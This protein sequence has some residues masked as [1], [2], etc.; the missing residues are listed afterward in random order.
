MPCLPPLQ[1]LRGVAVVWVIA[2]HY[3]ALRAGTADPMLAFLAQM[4]SLH[5][6]VQR[7]YLGV[8]LFFILSGF[9]LAL[10]W[11]LA[12]AEGRR[13]P[14]TS[15]FYRRRARRIVP[16]YYVQLLVLFAIVLPL[17]LGPRYWA[18]DLYVYLANGVAHGLFLHTTSP[19]T[20]ASM[21]V[22]GALWTLAVEA[23]FYL[24][25]PWIIPVVMRAPIRSCLA[26]LAAAIAWRHA[27]L[28][29]FGAIVA[30]QSHLGA[31]W[32]WP[33]QA[34][35][36]VLLLQLPTYA[37]H[38]ALGMVAGG[39]WLRWRTLAAPRVYVLAAAIAAAMLLAS[40]IFVASPPW[41]RFGWLVATIALAALVWS[42]AAGGRSIAS[43]EA[44]GRVSYSA[45]L[46][47]LPLLLLLGAYGDALAPA[48]RIPL[49]VACVA[50]VATS[51]WRYVERRFYAEREREPTV[52]A[53]AIASACNAATPQRTWKYR[54]A[55]ISRP[56]TSGA[57][58]KPVSMPE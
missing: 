2:F 35:R 49:Y 24:L 47:H 28:H 37:G 7:G 39:A 14:S 44:V 3:D 23:Q 13:P 12:R 57:S 32:G 8:D 4:P 18:R 42:A 16:A 41:Q 1:A 56:N 50:V 34:I 21:N 20:S 33:E 9:V 19:L 38:F 15:A 27:S 54:P 25:L 31:H 51:S 53:A 48:L 55:S 45:Y 43:L 29:E 30:V 17:L 10:P 26:A 46:Y 11:W 5:T 6:A 58:A 22:N 52:S 36:Q 40:V